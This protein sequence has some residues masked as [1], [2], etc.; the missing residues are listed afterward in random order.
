MF[1]KI[2]GG[3]YPTLTGVS[4]EDTGF[5]P[6]TDYGADLIDTIYVNDTPQ[7]RDRDG[8]AH[9]LV[10]GAD[11]AGVVAVA[12]AASPYTVTDLDRVLAVNTTAGAVTVK[13]PA[14][15]GP[16]VGRSLIYTDAA[17]KFGTN[18]L[19]LDGNGKNINGSATLVLNIDGEAGVVV[20]SGTEWSV[21]SGSGGAALPALHAD[22]HKA[23]GDDD[24]L[25]A[26]GAIGGG[27]PAAGTFT[28]ATITGSVDL[29]TSV[30]PSAATG[31]LKLYSES[32]KVLYRLNG[33]GDAY[34]ESLETVSGTSVIKKRMYAVSLAD[35][36]SLDIVLTPAALGGWGRAAAV[37]PTGSVAGLFSFAANAA[38]SLN[39]ATYTT[40]VASDTDTN[41]C[42]FANGTD[43]RVRNRLGSTQTIMVEI[44]ELVAV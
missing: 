26:P 8:I 28:S 30:A 31:K 43:L 39:G 44:T 27:T 34:L 17:R 36:A 7:I 3:D 24:L 20:Y 42:V 11:G 18:A 12:F 25:S 1:Q 38:T 13:L 15:G 37:G 29:A 6:P 23:G 40:F 10:V 19:T 4:V 41:L 14:D 33:T 16:F 21:I 2:L 5:D 35:E 22:T 32:G 9:P